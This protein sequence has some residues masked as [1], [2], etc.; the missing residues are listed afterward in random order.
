[1]NSKYFKN[2]DKE[3]KKSKSEINFHLNFAKI[4]AEKE[5]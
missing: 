2:K 3:I 4:N 1:M 5:K